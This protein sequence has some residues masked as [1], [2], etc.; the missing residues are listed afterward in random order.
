MLLQKG[1]F[2]NYPTFVVEPGGDALV[3]SVN[4]PEEQQTIIEKKEIY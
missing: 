1:G 3:C 4:N 2:I